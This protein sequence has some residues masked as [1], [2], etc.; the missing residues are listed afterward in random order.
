LSRASRT[1]IDGPS[2]QCLLKTLDRIFGAEVEIQT[3]RK[4]RRSRAVLNWNVAVP[5]D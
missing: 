5:H 4:C 2:Q 3:E 1:M